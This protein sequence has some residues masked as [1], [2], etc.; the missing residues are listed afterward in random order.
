MLGRLMGYIES[1]DGRSTQALRLVISNQQ[2]VATTCGGKRRWVGS[3]LLV[4][5]CF[6]P[7]WVVCRGI[8]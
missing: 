4:W 5:V 3:A 6:L 2:G 1:A 8:C 7:L